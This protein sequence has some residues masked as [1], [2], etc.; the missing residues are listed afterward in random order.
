MR[1]TL[2]EARKKEKKPEMI[3]NGVKFTEAKLKNAMCL[4]GK[5]FTFP[6]LQNTSVIYIKTSRGGEFFRCRSCT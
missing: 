6:D 2:K 4:C 3:V 5:P 1:K